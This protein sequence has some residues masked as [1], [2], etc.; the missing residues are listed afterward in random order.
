M[1]QHLMQEAIE[2]FS[3][4][5]FLKVSENSSK[6]RAVLQ[7]WEKC[8]GFSPS[9]LWSM[10]S[11]PGLFKILLKQSVLEKLFKFFDTEQ[12]RLHLTFLL[13]SIQ[14]MDEF[15]IYRHLTQKADKI[16]LIAISNKIT[17]THL[18]VYLS[19]YVIQQWS[20][21]EM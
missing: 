11:F 14:T 5:I 8:S 12:L 18:N 9:I 3:V 7:S 10:A 1:F 17:L 15:W 20:F 4:D 21:I 13:E 2:K 19:Q 6:D 16:M